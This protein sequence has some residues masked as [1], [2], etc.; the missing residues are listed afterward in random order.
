MRLSRINV[1][2][3]ATREVVK[4]P[5]GRSVS[6]LSADETLLLGT[7]V[8]GPPNAPAP[9]R[10][11]GADARFGQPNYQSVGPDGKPMT[12]ADATDLQ[13]HNTLMATR[14]GAPRVLFVVNTKTGEL[15]DIFHEHEW[16]GHLQ[17]SPTDRNL[18]MFCN[19]GTWHEVDRITARD[20][21]ATGQR[22]RNRS[23]LRRMAQ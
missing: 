22:P 17:F 16:L 6:S 15:H 19:E 11:P 23:C 18:I 10:L 13:L 4:L 7:Y 21:P 12:Y 5:A 20:W 8:D 1:N 9:N 3:G 2:T 14:A